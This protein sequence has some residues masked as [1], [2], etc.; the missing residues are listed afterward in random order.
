MYDRRRGN[1]KECAVMSANRLRSHRQND[2]KRTC[3]DAPFSLT[4]LLPPLCSSMIVSF[5]SG[6]TIDAGTRHHFSTFER[7]HRS[8]TDLH[9]FI[10]IYTLYSSDLFL[11]TP[12]CRF[13]WGILHS[14]P[15]YRSISI[16]SSTHANNNNNN[17]SSS[18]KTHHPSKLAPDT[19]QPASSK[20]S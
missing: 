1:V 9:S 6:I 17:N 14:P 10:F 8:L 11:E 13:L 20:S 7:E 4:F 12:P 2:K 16:I 19:A 3:S 15:I 18:C 5:L